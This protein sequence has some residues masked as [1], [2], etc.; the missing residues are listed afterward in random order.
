MARRLQRQ[1]IVL[2]LF[3]LLRRSLLSQPDKIRINPCF[4]KFEHRSCAVSED[5]P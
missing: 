3:L 2:T 1:E 5:D 4:L